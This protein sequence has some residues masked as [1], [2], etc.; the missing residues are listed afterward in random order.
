MEIKIKDYTARRPAALC[1]SA[2]CF[3]CCCMAVAQEPADTVTALTVVSV[4]A[5]KAPA[6]AVT[7]IDGSV[8]VSDA[9]LAMV[10]ELFGGSDMLRYLQLT[11][12]VSSISDYSSGLNVDGMDY[13]QNSFRLGGVPV[14]FPYHFGGI[15]STF[16]SDHYPSLVMTRSI[17]HAG[18][19][20]CLG[21]II[22][23]NPSDADFSGVKGSV[24]VGMLAS[25][26]HLAAKPTRRLRFDVSGRISYI[27]ALYHDL[28]ATES[29]DVW[30]NF[31]D[32]D[33]GVQYD[34]EGA[35]TL[36]A[37][38]HHNADK[39]T[40]GDTNYAMDDRLRWSNTL[41]GVAWH[42]AS[43]AATAYYSAMHSELSMAMEQFE[44]SVPADFREYGASGRCDFK[45]GRLDVFCG[46]TF[47]GCH[48]S[49]QW[50]K[51][52]GVEP[53]PR[54]RAIAY[55]AFLCKAFG[56]AAMRVWRNSIVLSCGLDLNYFIG[57]NGFRT[58][59]P[60]PRFT[61]SWLHSSGALSIHI[62]NL[63][64]YIHQSGF[65]DIGMASNFKFA[66]TAD[67]QPQSAWNFVL[68]ATQR[69]PWG[70][71]ADCEIYYKRVANQPE[72]MGSVLDLL[73]KDYV[74]TDHV[75][76]CDGYNVGG[77]IGLRR[78]YGA[79]TAMANYAYGV[80]RRRLPGDTHYFTASGEIRHSLNA[81]MAYELSKHWT[82]SAAFTLASGRPVTPVKAL[83]MIAERVMMEYGERNAASLPMRHRLDIGASYTFTTNAARL[84]HKVALSLINAYGHRNVE[85]STYTYIP[86]TA[87]YGRRM[88][89]SL[90][91]FL[92]SL[93]YSISF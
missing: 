49:P 14:Q 27:D 40:Y 74:A 75:V 82:V 56:E 64:Q 26:A 3:L 35:G 36:S 10:P 81:T 53:Q 20:D 47:D 83:Y 5:R 11:S 85:L 48:Y 22:D 13:S 67:C 63:R 8:K 34:L 15:F 32:I 91:R 42:G 80:A 69:L 84:H 12:G 30:Y 37:L 68:T 60:S 38:V 71:Y 89:Y 28:I 90:Y 24:N 17:H 88:V 6:T 41:A 31:H 16:N 25:Q 62:G 70:I 72:Y 44:L 39:L 46:A 29:T 57:I 21:G 45:A 9:A 50:V 55:D 51:T 78:S 2:A 4:T 65:S 1:A 33:A 19:Y 87:S 7:A 59:D 92:P 77:N 73:N 93:S 61:A 43:A 76:T 86:D 66:A 52:A 23:V 54:G 18:S 79:F 58:F